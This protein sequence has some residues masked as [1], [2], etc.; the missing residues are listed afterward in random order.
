MSSTHLSLHYHIVF[1][2]KE[3]YPLIKNEFRPRL[4]AFLGGCVKTLGGVPLAIGGTNDHVHLLIGLRA[5]HQLSNVIKEIKVASSKC[6]HEEIL[7]KEFA[8]QIGYG[9][10]TVG[11]SNLEQVRNYVLNQEIHHQK[12]NFETEYVQMLETAN[13]EYDEKYL[14]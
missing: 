1:S 3:R 2:T 11:I 9:A 10:F 7:F 6:I 13:I 5:T 12:K 8:W 14:W 4:H